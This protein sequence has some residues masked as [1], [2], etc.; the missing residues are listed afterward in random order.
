M[1]ALREIEKHQVD[2]VYCLGDIVG[3]GADPSACVDLVRKH[4]RASVLGNHDVAV[5]LESGI[6]TLPRDG[7]VA[8]RHNRRNLSD[9]QLEYLAGLPLTLRVDGCTFVHATPRDPQDWVRF[10]SLATVKDQFNYFDTD[11]CFV[12]H[13]HVPAVVAERLGTFKVKKGNRY[14]INVGSVG[15]PRDGN[16]L[17]SFVIFDT[18]EPSHELVRIPYDISAAAGRIAAEGLPSSLGRRLA[19]GV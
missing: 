17:L 13:T 18:S 2:A 16:P 15:Q 5:A 14:I 10:D 7:Q 19:K 9:A 12:G 8:A 11:F 6:A 1:A 3:Y 4:C